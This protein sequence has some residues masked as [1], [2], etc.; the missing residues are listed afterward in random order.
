[1]EAGFRLGRIDD[2]VAGR[3][4]DRIVRNASIH[5]LIGACSRVETMTSLAGFE[6]LLRGKPVTTH[7]QPFYAGWGLTE[8]LCPIARR[9]RTV[10]LD[11]LVAAALILYPH[12]LDPESGQPCGP[13]VVAERLA[14]A[15]G[16]QRTAGERLADGARATAARALLLGQSL[17][18]AARR[19]P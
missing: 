13:E 7:G 6:A 5:Q 15:A 8:D 16:R 2:A 12:Y 14:A 17:R 3:F 10:S 11:E 18:L 1:V 9:T 19:A 4:A